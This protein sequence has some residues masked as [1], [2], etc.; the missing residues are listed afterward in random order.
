[1][2]YDVVVFLILAF[3]MYRGAK[4]GIVWQLAVIA[5]L[6]LCFAFAGTASL[7]LAPYIK[8]KP[9]LDRWI[10]MFILYIAFS[11]LAFGAARVMR[12]WIEKAKFVEFDQHLGAFLGLVKGVTF[13]LV[14]TFFSVTLSPDVRSQVMS[15]YSGYGAAIV[16]DRLHPVMP[17]GLQNVLEPYIHQLDRPDMDLR[18]RDDH[19]NNEANL[20][21][22]AIAGNEDDGN[23]H[24]SSPEAPND[25]SGLESEDQ[26]KTLVER[27]P[28]IIDSQLKEAAYEAL[29]NTDEEDRGE[30]IQKLSS[31]IPS[32]IRTAADEWRNGKPDSNS[33]V[34]Q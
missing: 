11:F 30:L 14:V 20:P 10:A 28:G 16:M 17:D 24:D 13:A 18:F 31:G 19:R 9:P 26:I 21:S 34:R 25:D 32:V 4:R 3:A 6:I 23:S 7:A 33:H 12:D 15:S 5:S 1:M 8:V 27:L 2:W 29:R 22:S